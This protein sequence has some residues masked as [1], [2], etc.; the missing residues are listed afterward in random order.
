MGRA[1]YICA[2][3]G[4][5]S[6]KWLGRCPSCGLW[7]SFEEKEESS[8]EYRSKGSLSPPEVVR[9]AEVTTEEVIRHRFRSSQLSR[10]FGGGIAKGSVLLV[11]GEPGI[12]KSTFLLQLPSMFEEPV[13]TLYVSG[14]ETRF[15]VSD[16]ARRIG[17][18]EH[19]WFLAT[20]S[21][22]QL[23]EA[24]KSLAPELLIVDSV[25][26]IYSSEISAQAGSVSQVRAVA[27]SLVEWAKRNNTTVFLVG[28]VTKGG[29]IAGP[30]L[31]EHIV[32]VVVHL[33]GDRRSPLR[34][35]KCVKNRFGP[36]DNVVLFEME[37]TG[38]KE[39][40]NPSAYFVQDSTFGR[41]GVV[42][43]SVVEGTRAFVVEVQALVA[44]AVHPAMARRVASMF[45]VRR[46]FFLLAV[47]EKHLEVSFSGMDV[48]VNIP[49]GLSVRDTAV[50][51]A[52]VLAIY[53]SFV[54][55]S[56]PENT[57]VIGEV[58]LA[59]EVRWA[60]DTTLRL[61]EAASMGINRALIP[62]SF[63][64]KIN[65]DELSRLGLEL[66]SVGMLREAV[67]VLF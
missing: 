31:L 50:D 47:M 42:L 38:L 26:T 64:C 17:A 37:S 46:L 16:R 39:V 12:G 62:S 60:K 4:Y 56:V 66:V 14:E 28:H 13:R 59:G 51:L 9:L 8:E 10:F 25:Q 15:Q 30:K 43:S 29:A 44:P 65:E 32:D 7:G 48:Y 54:N 5:E 40:E 3:C 33:E 58:G 11:S 22:E 34:V 6:F 2:H 24:A 19:I 67:E 55:K 53:S 27:E 21:L 49:G 23:L 36:T 61:K 1:R 41:P 52:V 20:Q 63:K 18:V 57:I 45:D 35:L